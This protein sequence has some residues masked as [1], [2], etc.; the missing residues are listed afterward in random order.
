MI[1][2]VTINNTEYEVEVEVGKASIIRTTAVEAPVSTIVAAAPS[3]TAAPIAAP[4]VVAPTQNTAGGETIKSP[5][6]GTILD[7]KVTA[8]VSVKKGEIL[9][10]LEAMKMENEIVAPHDGIVTHVAVQK[11]V[12]V[13]TGDALVSIK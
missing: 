4:V 12:T 13:S 7:V 5:M 2:V 8:G 11:G 1:Y 6:P 10:I 9:L 3:T